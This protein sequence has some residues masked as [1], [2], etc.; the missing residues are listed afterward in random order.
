MVFSIMSVS[1]TVVSILARN[2]NYNRT[3]RQGLVSGRIASCVPAYA[4]C[5]TGTFQRVE[6]AS[7]LAQ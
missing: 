1:L 5:E 7:P 2:I 3:W 4:V 6:D